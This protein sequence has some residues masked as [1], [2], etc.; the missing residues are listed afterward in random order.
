M[1]ILGPVTGWRQQA[2]SY[3]LE[4]ACVRFGHLTTLRPERNQRLV[5]QLVQQ[6]KDLPTKEGAYSTQVMEEYTASCSEAT[7]AVA[8]AGKRNILIYV[9]LHSSQ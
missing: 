5:E 3:L 1:T 6:P 8:P 9:F 4:D 7:P 2:F